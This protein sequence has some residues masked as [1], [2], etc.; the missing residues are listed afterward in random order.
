MA[1]SSVLSQSNVVGI[2][3]PCEIVQ[4][5]KPASVWPNIVHYV[6]PSFQAKRRIS[7]RC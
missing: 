5:I 4:R 2:A 7:L 1:M 3:A 6:C